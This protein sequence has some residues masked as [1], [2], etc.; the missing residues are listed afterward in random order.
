MILSVALLRRRAFPIISARP[1]YQFPLTVRARPV[2]R[3][4]DTLGA[5]STLEGT[6]PRILRILSER[7]SAAFTLAPHLKHA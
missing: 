1:L 2:Q 6:N 3:T 7:R 5:E 4:F